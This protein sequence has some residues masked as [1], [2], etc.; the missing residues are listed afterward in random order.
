MEDSDENKIIDEAKRFIKEKKK[1]LIKKFADP[2]IYKPDNNPVS[3]FMAG[4]PGA[5][6]TE[7]SKRLI[8]RFSTKP[9]R[10]DA[11]DIRDMFDG[12]TG[13]NAHLFQPAC[14]IGVNK[15]YDYV[16]DN[17]LSVILDGTFAYAGALD[18]VR[19]SVKKSRK[20]EVYYLYQDP[21]IAWDF[22]IKR[23]AVEHRHVSREIF[24]KSFLLS[25][26][27]VNKAKE[28]FKERI[29]LNLIIKNFNTGLERFEL[30]IANVD[31][32]LD[33]IYTEDELMEIVKSL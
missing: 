9:V 22:T 25:K 5:G 23:E 27:N 11:D 4:S 21:I 31:G 3:L 32:Y 15:L 24:V 33:Q 1:E 17:K 28:E 26:E 29:E 12:Y 19:R 16:L 10:I 8:E 30:N 13:G 14:T 18:N 7:F 20:V 2:E 6:K